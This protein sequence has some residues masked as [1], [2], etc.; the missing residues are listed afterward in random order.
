MNI[1]GN[2]FLTGCEGQLGMAIS[3]KLASKRN[4]IFG[5]DISAE[6]K[7]NYLTKY[8]KGSVTDRKSF[9]QLFDL[10][11]YE[12]NPCSFTLIN[13][14][15]FSVF[16]PSEER[17][18]DEFKQVTEVNML[19][20]LFGMTEFFLYIQALR[21]TYGNLENFY[22][23]IN[24]ASV[25]GMISPNKKI[26]SDTKRSN[27]EI[28][29]ASKAGLIQMTKY[30][31]TRYADVPITV[32][33]VSPGGILN[34]NLQGEEFISNYSKLVPMNRLSKDYEIADVIKMLINTKNEYLTGQNIAVD[35]GM[36]SW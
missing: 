26:Y 34:E 1:E 32:N 5:M 31:A 30:F 23:I 14:A 3:K 29:G 21:K 18:V 24:I 8:L 36:T 28:Y 20:P 35:G 9:S 33:S 15:G 7:N 16:T 10:L 4:N 6:S 27:S 12:E 19:G 25:Y 11:N 2:I 13:N 22:S 17:T